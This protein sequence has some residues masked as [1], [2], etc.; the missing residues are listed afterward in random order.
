MKK[1][2]QRSIYIMFTLAL[3]QLFSITTYAEKIKV[4]KVKGNQAIVESST[5]LEEGQSYEINTD[6]ISQDVDY[7]SSVPKSRANSFTLGMKFDFLKSSSLQSTN[8]SVQ[9]RYGW[10]FSN[11]EFG[12][13]A[14][15][16]SADSGAGATTTLL[17][18]GYFD[19]NLV[20]NRDPKQIIYGPFILLALGTTTYPSSGTGG[21]S[22]TMQT[23]LGGFLS[24]F[25]G[26]G[27][28]AALR[29]ELFGIYQQVN[30]STS[31]NTVTG[32]GFRGLLVFYF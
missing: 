12:I 6:P 22:N 4:K 18:G 23:N 25:I 28:T 26:A 16:S 20:I 17:G 10:N 31:Q 15:A 13:L 32:A 29:G 11:L 3:I 14:D 7:K 9:S 24:Y 30:T 8:F 21:S 2:N 1:N 5:P 27:S 19:Y